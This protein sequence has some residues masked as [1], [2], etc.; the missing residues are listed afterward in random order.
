MVL[1]VKP[2]HCNTL[3]P[4][5]TIY[6]GQQCAKAGMTTSSATERC[7]WF[8]GPGRREQ[9]ESKADFRAMSRTVQTSTR[10]DCAP[11]ACVSHEI[12]TRLSRRAAECL[13]RYEALAFASTARALRE[14]CDSTAIARRNLQGCREQYKPAYNQ[15]ILKENYYQDLFG[16]WASRAKREQGGFLRESANSTV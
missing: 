14:H 4:S 10:P 15:Q 9:R 3:N 12:P 13:Y 7:Y 6:S 1:F 5:C 16:F 11:G 8:E 2:R